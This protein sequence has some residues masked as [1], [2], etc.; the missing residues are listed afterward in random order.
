[1]LRCNASDCLWNNNTY[2]ICHYLDDIT[3]DVHG[4][5]N[6]Y[7]KITDEEFEMIKRTMEDFKTFCINIKEDS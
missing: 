5:C 6:H 7:R 4:S 2:H 1:M 3:I